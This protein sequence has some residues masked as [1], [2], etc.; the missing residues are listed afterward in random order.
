MS[1]FHVFFSEKETDVIVRQTGVEETH[2]FPSLW[3]ATRHVRGFIAE[4][5]GYVT[6][7]EGGRQNRI[8]IW[9]AEPELGHPS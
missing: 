7:H 4:R 9:A 3:E 5:G 1:D 8:P 2:I 6:V